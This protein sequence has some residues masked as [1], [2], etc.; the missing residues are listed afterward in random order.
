MSQPK[1]EV[2]QLGFWLV[3]SALV[4]G[5]LGSLLKLSV[6]FL[7]ALAMQGGIRVETEPA[8]AAPFEARPP[9][10][11]LVVTDAS[12]A[13]PP[14]PPSELPEPDAIPASA[15]AAP[16]PTLPS[17]LAGPVPGLTPN[18]P[19]PG[20]VW[21]TRE[22]LETHSAGKIS[23]IF[24]QLF[25]KQAGYVRQVRMP[26]PPLLFADRALTV[27]GEPG[28]MKKGRVVT[29]TDVQPL[30]AWYLHAGRMAP[31]IVIESGQADLLLISWLGADFFNEG[32]RVYRLLGCD[33]TFYGEL[34]KPGDT[35]T[36]DIY[37]D[38]HATTGD[39]R[40]FF[41]HYDC[42]IGDRMLLSVRNGQAGFFTEEE[43]AG[44][45]GVLWDAS[46]DEPKPDARLDPPPKL[47]TKRSFSAE[48]LQH[49]VGGDGLGDSGPRGGTATVECSPDWTRQL[50]ER[51]RTRRQVGANEPTV[52]AGS[53]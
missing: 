19:E 43:L 8:P 14:A 15:G 48:D 24:G 5:A 7:G 10:L 41:F 34:P 9:D 51:L 17:P 37:V 25:E 20:T 3:F 2:S 27:E 23:E 50:Q 22:Q 45:G 47:T 49:F 21:L 1:L 28:T 18:L 30:G 35:L 26:E 33:L 46:E 52:H 16:A 38:G 11:R 40:L 4:W 31:G 36:Y 6:I 13:A 32:E 42:R 12:P 29:E 44:S 39:V 53:A